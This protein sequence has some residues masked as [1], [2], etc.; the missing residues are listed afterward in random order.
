MDVRCIRRRP[1]AVQ[2]LDPPNL[3]PGFHLRLRHRHLCCALGR[4]LGHGA[5][6]VRP[7]LLDLT[8]CE[9]GS[10][11]TSLQLL[12]GVD[13]PIPRV[14]AALVRILRGALNCRAAPLL[15]LEALDGQLRQLQWRTLRQDQ[16][17][18]LLDPAC[19]A[20][21]LQDA[22]RA[23]NPS[24]LGLFHVQLPELDV[25]RVQRLLQDSDGEPDTLVQQ[26]T[27]LNLAQPAEAFLHE[28]QVEPVLLPQ[29]RRHLW[30]LTL[31]IL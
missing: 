28:S 26:A 5:A 22:R 9:V 1:H 31:C 14:E 23:Q 8:S 30:L 20:E 6:P 27:L 2:R 12:E 11:Q 17:L 16:P 21:D 15:L 29:L 19:A 24:H 4:L 10:C 3:L 25:G 18:A 7:V 13:L